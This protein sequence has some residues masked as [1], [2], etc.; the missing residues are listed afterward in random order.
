MSF[1]VSVYGKSR[2]WSRVL[3]VKYFVGPMGQIYFDH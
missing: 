3:E 2:N 1:C